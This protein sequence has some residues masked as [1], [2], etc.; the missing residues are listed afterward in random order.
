MKNLQK[1]RCLVDDAR[2]GVYHFCDPESNITQ[3]D[4]INSIN[5]LGAAILL[6]A[7][8][9]WGVEEIDKL[10]NILRECRPFVNNHLDEII[11]EVLD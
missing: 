3:G 7:D 10:K 2:A 4:I 11:S 9:A 1:V 5:E 6:V 8:K